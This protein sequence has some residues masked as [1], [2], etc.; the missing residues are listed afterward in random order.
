MCFFTLVAW[1]I[2]HITNHKEP[3][4][5]FEISGEINLCFDQSTLFLLPLIFIILPLLPRKQCRSHGVIVLIWILVSVLVLDV[6]SSIFFGAQAIFEV[7][8]DDKKFYATCHIFLTQT[9]VAIVVCNYIN[10]V[11]KDEFFSM[12]GFI[13]GTEIL[14]MDMFED[15]SGELN[16]S[17]D[18]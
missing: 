13:H 9:I 18:A 12:Q 16:C 17:R 3:E 7:F 1:I 8:D 2:V 4:D 6:L 14:D 5:L 11:D 15:S 10:Q